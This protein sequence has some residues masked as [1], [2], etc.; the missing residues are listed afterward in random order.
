[1]KPMA[2]RMS[3]RDID[4]HFYEKAPRS[5]FCDQCGSVLDRTY[6]PAMLEIYSGKPQD[7]GS[8][9]DGQ[10]ICS[11]RF[12]AFCETRKYQV[13][14]FPIKA[15]VTIYHFRPAAIL[16]FDTERR[17]TVFSKRCPRCGT[18]DEVIGSI[19]VFLRDV[20]EPIESGIFRTDLEFGSGAQ[21]G[22]KIIVG[23]ET[24]NAMVT[25]KFRG[26]TLVAISNQPA[27]LR[28]SR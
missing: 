25:R 2:Y 26:C 3:L 15:R 22:P 13:E 18:Y 6:V 28:S 12:K 27:A 17:N 10:V 4:A 20:V 5:V 8:T 9:Y 19:P 7:L 24:R 11:E 16:R 21:K 23:I 14:F 1:M